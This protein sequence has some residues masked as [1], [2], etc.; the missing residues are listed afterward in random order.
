MVED[1]RRLLGPRFQEIAGARLTAEIPLSERLVNQLVAEALKRS[2]DGPVE[3]AEVQVR[4]DGELAVRLRLRRPRFVPPVVVR[5]RIEKQ[6]T[7][8]EPELVLRWDLTGIAALAKLATP[9]LSFT[10]VSR[11]G[12]I[13]DGDRV[14]LDVTRLAREQGAGEL[15][16]YLTALRVETRAQAL[17]LIFELRVP[18]P[19]A[20]IGA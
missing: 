7:P 12:I 10:N 14:A 9:V 8:E 13:V 19:P 17:V 16:D 2:T 4:T 1:L 5:L 15:L 20:T 11:P 18:E 3:A 6:P